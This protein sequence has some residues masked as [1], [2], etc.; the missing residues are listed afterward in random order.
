MQN[1]LLLHVEQGMTSGC[2]LGPVHTC[3][4][5]WSTFRFGIWSSWELISP[6]KNVFIQVFVSLMCRIVKDLRSCCKPYNPAAF[7]KATTRKEKMQAYCFCP[8]IKYNL[9]EVSGTFCY[10]GSGWAR[11]LWEGIL[12]EP[13]K[14]EIVKSLTRDDDECTFAVHIPTWGL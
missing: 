7:V 11:R 1:E 10:C 3:R 5:Y 4:P 14:V 6:Y 2:C 9:D 13:V 8:M 12:D